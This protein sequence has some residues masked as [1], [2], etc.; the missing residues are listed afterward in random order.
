MRRRRPLLAD[1]AKARAWRDRSARAQAL[2]D[3]ERAVREAVF[4]RD[5]GC[6]LRRLDADHRC[7]GPLT[8]HHL[9]KRDRRYTVE[10]GVALC[11]GGNVA[12][13]DDPD[14][15]H[16]LGLVVRW[17]ESF[18]EVNALRTRLLAEG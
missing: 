18:D 15:H 13:E 9:L 8:Y 6:L 7:L 4:R 16:A 1:P 14:H 10:G 12:V 17:S 2:D 11:A 5:G 3:D